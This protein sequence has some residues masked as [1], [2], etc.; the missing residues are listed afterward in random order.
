MNLKKI[1]P[2]IALAM[3]I[4]SPVLA[5]PITR[6]PI[7][8]KILLA[9]PYCQAVEKQYG[10]FTSTCL[11]QLSLESGDGNDYSYLA[12]HARNFFGFKGGDNY[13][14]P[15][16]RGY[17]FY[18]SLQDSV[19]DYGINVGLGKHYRRARTARTPQAQLQAISQAGYASN[20]AYAS[21]VMGRIN[22]YGLTKFD[23]KK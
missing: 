7:P 14:G 21:H 6:E 18:D 23:L 9:V 22:K 4:N 10:I 16:I 3:A 13:I 12:T 20:P 15:Q 5:K 17:R 1:I 19:I 8:N 2:S 11:G